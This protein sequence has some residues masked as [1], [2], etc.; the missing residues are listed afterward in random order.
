MTAGSSVIEEKKKE[1]DLYLEESL[2][3]K[4]FPQLS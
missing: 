1:L 2:T 4:I 3:K